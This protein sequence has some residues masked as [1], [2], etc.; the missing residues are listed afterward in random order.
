MRA[1]IGKGVGYCYTAGRGPTS[2]WIGHVTGQLFCFY[3]KICLPSIFNSVN[4]W[5]SMSRILLDMELADENVVEVLGVWIDRNVKGYSFWPP[6]EYKPTKQPFWCTRNSHGIVW[7]SGD[8]VYN[9]LPNIVS[10]NVNSGN[11]RKKNKIQM[12][13]SWQFFG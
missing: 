10:R 9:K 7:K 12:Q 5:S 13:K 3:V 11:V 6:K 1:D 8:L 4:F 2:S